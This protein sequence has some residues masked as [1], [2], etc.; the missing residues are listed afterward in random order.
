[1]QNFLIHIK[2]KNKI[3]ANYGLLFNHVMALILFV[4]GVV[5]YKYY[6][7][8]WWRWVILGFGIVGLSYFLFNY[9][10]IKQRF[11]YIDFL[12]LLGET[13]ILAIVFYYWV[14]AILTAIQIYLFIEMRKATR[15]SFDDSFI[16]LKAPFLSR[17][18]MWSQIDNIVI[19]DG[20]LTIDF[21]NN[22]LL[23]EEIDTDKNKIDEISFNAYCKKMLR[24]DITLVEPFVI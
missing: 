23:Q 19:R 17:K 21:K 7:V 22:K 5:L 12:V 6:N 2:N 8:I 11:N 4:V 20:L 13:L 24:K 14:V 9:K 1:M 15:F 3:I 16:T 10:A 18:Y